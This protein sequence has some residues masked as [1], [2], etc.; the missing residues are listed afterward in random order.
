MCVRRS[1]ARSLPFVRSYIS[2]GSALAAIVLS[3][4]LPCLLTGEESARPAELHRR[5][6]CSSVRPSVLLLLLRLSAMA[7]MIAAIHTEAAG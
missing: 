2:A 4:V 5:S 7:E 1:L 3:F 6:M